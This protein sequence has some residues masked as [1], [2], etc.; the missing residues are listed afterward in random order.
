MKRTLT[1]ALLAGMLVIS[2]CATKGYVRQQV[3]PVQGR[4]DQIAEDKLKQDERIGQVE[5][6]VERTE[7]RVGSAEEKLTTVEGR[8]SDALAKSERTAREVE[9]LRQVLGNLDDYNLSAESTVNFGFDQAELTDE[10]KAALDQ[11][12]AQ[13]GAAKRYL[14]SVEG[15]TD[16]IGSDGYNLD[17][18]RRRADSVVRYLV[19]RHNIP[20]YRIFMLGFGKQNLVAE[21]RGREERARNRRVE[22][23]LYSADGAADGMAAARPSSN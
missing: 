15:H 18:S 2:G 16:P 14:I 22:V 11:F 6:D 1:I 12:V 20:V 13:S 23:K 3:E 7:M 10:A 19:T 4:L 5:T 21:G 9:E 8:L 17:L